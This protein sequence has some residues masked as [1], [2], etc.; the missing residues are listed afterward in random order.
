MKKLLLFLSLFIFSVN[1]FSQKIFKAYSNNNYDKIESYLKKKKDP[2]ILNKDNVPLLFLASSDNNLPIVKLLIKYN[3]TIDIKIGNGK[4]TPF[5]MACAN[6]SYDVVAYLIE[7]NATINY[8]VEAAGNQ[9]P[10]RFACKTGSVKLVR[11]LLENNAALEDCP[12]DCVTPL[13]QAARSNHFELVKFLIE[14]GAN[15]NHQAR[16]KECALNQAIKN[17]N[18]KMVEF[19]KQKGAKN[20]TDKDGLSSIDL[21]KKTNDE[22]IISLVSKQ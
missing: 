12:D 4:V 3:A 22:T 1:V 6:N 16:D 17:K 9:T 15:I 13:I 5:F 18:M 2:N 8:R 14:K 21:A 20:M 7:K 11:L 10:I 19:L